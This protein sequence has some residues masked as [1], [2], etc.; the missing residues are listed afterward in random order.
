MDEIFN[1]NPYNMHLDTKYADL[2]WA[3]IYDV[4]TWFILCSYLIPMNLYVLCEFAKYSVKFFIQWDEDMVDKR[5]PNVQHGAKVNVSTVVEELGQIQ[6]ILSDKTGT[7]TE[8]IMSLTGMSASGIMLDVHPG[9]GHLLKS[10][11][12]RRNSRDGIYDETPRGSRTSRTSKTVLPVVPSN[13]VG[14]EQKGENND[15]DAMGKKSRASMARHESQKAFAEEKDLILL[16]MA[17]CS[18]VTTNK[19]TGEFAGESPDE[20]ALAK[21]AKDNGFSLKH[22]GLDTCTLDAAAN[23]PEWVGEFEVLAQLEFTSSRRRMETVIRGPRNG[24]ILLFSKGADSV[25]FT[26]TDVSSGELEG[27]TDRSTRHGRDLNA[28]RNHLSWFSQQGLRTLVFSYFEVDEEMVEKWMEKWHDAKAAVYNR[29]KKEEQ[30]FEELERLAAIIGCT[31]VEDRLQEGVKETLVALRDAGIQIA[32]L[33][34]DK[35]ETAINIGYNTGLMRLNHTLLNVVNFS[36]SCNPHAQTTTTR[37]DLLRNLLD[38]I[39]RT[40]SSQSGTDIEPALV[41]D[42]ASTQICLS[43]PEEK[44]LLC[45]LMAKCKTAI[46]NRMT[47]KQKAAMVRL[48]KNDFQR[49]SLAVGDG[50]ND[51][52]MIREANVGVGIRGK[53]GLQAVNS[54]DFALSQFKHLRKLLL[55][56]GRYA[57]LRVTR[58]MAAAFFANLTFNI[59]IVLYGFYSGF[60]GQPIFTDF[61]MAWYNLLFTLLIQVHFVFFDRDCSPATILSSPQAYMRLSAN[62]GMFN[63]LTF[64]KVFFLSLWHGGLCFFVSVYGL[65]NEPRPANGMDLTSL[66]Q[67]QLIWATS[68]IFGALIHMIMQYNFY[69]KYGVA[70]IVCDFFFYTFGIWLVQTIIYPDFPLGD[71][72]SLVGVTQVKTLLCMFFIII[73][74]LLPVFAVQQFSRWI[75]TQ[76]YHILEEINALGLEIVKPEYRDSA[77]D[78]ADRSSNTTPVV[79]ANGI[80]M[81]SSTVKI[82]HPRAKKKLNLELETI[83]SDREISL[84][85]K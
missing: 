37:Q 4:F 29:A 14:E 11:H 3:Y 21:A 58:T 36:K 63:A 61:I 24:K 66:G 49:V 82:I 45:Q 38:K 5:D 8:N 19:D 10:L 27:E 43:N 54:A 40:C 84:D 73:T 56:H 77:I 18:T 32:M 31:A 30:A 16:A 53:E 71:D 75:N 1:Q 65:G 70:L 64:L 76:P 34:G 85:E 42:G 48:L 26:R 78:Y 68:V 81:L 74:S 60:S 39:D 22:R 2:N 9:T 50:A 79:P 62:G 35:Q 12:M 72:V 7:L 25:M 13:G 17:V 44:E 80:S 83:V 47:P 52:S 6:Y 15:G 28:L 46:C 41:I 33:T 51:V 69:T 23:H 67:F 20:V 55:V 59:P 57:Y